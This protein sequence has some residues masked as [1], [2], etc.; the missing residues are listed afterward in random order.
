MIEPKHISYGL[1]AL[2]IG[3]A[4]WGLLANSSG[5]SKS[6][7]QLNLIGP[8]M[9]SNQQKPNQKQ[10]VQGV[11]LSESGNQM[12]SPNQQ[13]SESNLVSTKVWIFSGKI[14]SP[15]CPR[16]SLEKAK[17]HP[18]L[19]GW[20]V[21]NSKG[22]FKVGLPPGEYT[23]LAEFG[24]DLYLNNFLGDGS[25]ASVQVYPEKITEIQIVNTENTFY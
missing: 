19:I 15:N 2:F 22:K 8:T 23:L 18:N 4:A 9:I 1:S 12:P 5:E 21:S 13:R 14:M 17:Q 16:W 20:T 3:M 10:G 11:V 25:Y 6:M 24:S 7:S